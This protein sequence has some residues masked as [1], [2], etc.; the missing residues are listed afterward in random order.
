MGDVIFKLRILRYL[1]AGAYEEWRASIWQRDLDSTYCCDGRECVCM[2]TT[3][4]ELWSWNAG[5]TPSIK[6][7]GDE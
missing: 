5:L 6:G 2:A 1:L 7:P 4:R 3:V